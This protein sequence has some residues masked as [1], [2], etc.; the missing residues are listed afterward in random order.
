[1]PLIYAGL[2]LSVEHPQGPLS[3]GAHLLL[4]GQTEDGRDLA[5]IF[6]D[7]VAEES[8][9]GHAAGVNDGVHLEVQHGGHGANVLGHRPGPGRPR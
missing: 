3:Q 2:L 8:L 5:H 9:I 1:M 6:C 4:A 7:V